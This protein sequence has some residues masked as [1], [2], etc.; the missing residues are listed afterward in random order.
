MV[1]ILLIVSIHSNYLIL[2]K[3]K[4][5]IPNMS[6]LKLSYLFLGNPVKIL[7]PNIYYSFPILILS[8]KQNTC[9]NETPV[10]GIFTLWCHWTED[11]YLCFSRILRSYISASDRFQPQAFDR[12]KLN[13]QNV[14]SYLP[15]SRIVIYRLQ[16]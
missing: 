9:I 10:Y 3:L 6:G 12:Y 8:K 1:I 4:S 2:N 5:L 13:Y 16:S 7:I 11:N 14:H 15:K